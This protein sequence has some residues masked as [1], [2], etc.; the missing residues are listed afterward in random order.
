MSRT[1]NCHDNT[2][3]E[4]FWATRKSELTEARIFDSRAQA[5]TEVFAY[6]EVCRN[7]SRF[8]R[9]LGDISP[10]DYENHQAKMLTTPHSA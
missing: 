10:V 2:A 6:L 4:S 1:G 5:R 3:M 8:H 7:R 9:A